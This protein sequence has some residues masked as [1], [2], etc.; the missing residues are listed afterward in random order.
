LAAINQAHIN[1]AGLAADGSLDLILAALFLLVIR[2]SVQGCDGFILANNA[3]QAADDL[4]LAKSEAPLARFERE[5][6]ELAARKAA[7]ADRRRDA[8]YTAHI[9]DS[10]AAKVL[11]AVH[12]EAVELESKIASLSDA[13]AEAQKGLDIAK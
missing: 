10:A 7:L 1:K 2:R 6:D 13:V 5:R 11:D 4:S 12:R 3:D 9:G 8:A